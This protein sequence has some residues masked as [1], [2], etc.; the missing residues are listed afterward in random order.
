MR[1]DID[2][3]CMKL[4]HDE[5]IRIVQT[6]LTAIPVHAAGIDAYLDNKTPSEILQQELEW[7]L[8]LLRMG[9]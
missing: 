3:V 8:S 2:K 5:L 6:R 9:K 7:F 4:S 1:R